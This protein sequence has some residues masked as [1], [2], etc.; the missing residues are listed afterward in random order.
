MTS[1][2]TVAARRDAELMPLLLRAAE[3]RMRPQDLRAFALRFGLLDGT[4]RTLA[5]AGDELGISRERVRQLINRGIDSLRRSAAESLAA[6]GR[7]SML[8][9]E[10]IRPD[11]LGVTARCLELAERELP[12]LPVQ[13]AAWLLLSLCGYQGRRRQHLVTAV[14]SAIRVAR[15]DVKRKEE[16]E[17]TLLAHLAGA[18]WPS[19]NVTP[20]VP[21]LAAVRRIT[22]DPERHTGTF[23][24]QKMHRQVE[25]ESELE[26]QFLSRLEETPA[27]AA[28]QEQ[29]MAIEYQSRGV[30]RVY[31]PDVIAT[32]TDRRVLVVELKPRF[33]MALHANVEKWR[34]AFR[35]CHQ[36]GWGF[37][38][39]DGRRSM[40]SLLEYRLHEPFVEAIDSALSRGPLDWPAYQRIRDAADVGGDE[41]LA[42]VL[43]RRLRWSLAP[44]RLAS[45]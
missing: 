19:D 43:Q 23:T 39:T 12:H 15:V 24:S 30:T 37:L 45:A 34:A 2:E 8:V 13:V 11:E 28:Y 3:E 33:Q 5:E 1:T 27:V 29:P 25:F 7:L 20:D 40:N 17:R 6:P 10:S 4:A 41:F 26:R 14:G 16:I 9:E 32:L 21:A 18:Y 36:R 35:F 38:V 31:Y 44:F 42:L 22:R